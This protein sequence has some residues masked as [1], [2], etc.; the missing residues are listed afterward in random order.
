L[1]A[2][3]EVTT[4]SFKD[5]APG[6]ARRTPKRGRPGEDV[7]HV[8]IPKATHALL[9]VFAKDRG[10]TFGDAATHLIG[11]GLLHEY[12]LHHEIAQPEARRW[13]ALRS[14]IKA[15]SKGSAAD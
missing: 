14:A 7:K 2:R 4:V 1:S 15:R 6:G 8:K 5:L 10:M 12:N 11:I 3:L 9:Y 13:E